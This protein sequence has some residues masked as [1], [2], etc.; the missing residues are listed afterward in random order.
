MDYPNRWLSRHAYTTLADHVLTTSQ[1]ITA[2]F[3][4]MFDL[5]DDRISTVPTGIDLEIFSPSGVKAK[6]HPTNRARSSE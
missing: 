6:F 3:Q 1:K 5:P 4:E 2:H